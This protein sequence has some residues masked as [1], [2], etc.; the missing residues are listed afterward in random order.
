MLRI[1][2]KLS[3][4]ASSSS[5]ALTANQ[6]PTKLSPL[7]TS[8]FR[9][10][11]IGLELE[12]HMVVPDAIGMINYALK[13]WRTERSL[14]AF[15]MGLCVLKH[16]ISTELTEG[17]DPKRE[18]SKG[19][20]MLAMSTILY[21]RGEYTEAIEKIEDVQEL[22]NSYLGVRVAALETQAGLYLELRQDDLA[23]AV[24]DKCMKVVENQRQ[25]KDFEVQAKDFEAHFLRAKALKGLIELVNGNV[26]SAD[27]F[28]DKSHDDSKYWDGTAG[29]SYAEFLHKKQDYTKATEVYRSVVHGAVQIKRAGNPYLGAGNMSVDELIVGSMCALGQL[30]ALTGNYYWAEHRLGQALSRAEEAYGDSKHPTLGVAL[31]SIALMYR[32]KA[33][34]EHSSSLLI[35]EGLYRKVMDILKVPSEET[36]T[37][38]AA[39][40][41]DRS[42]IAALARGAYAEVLSVQ[43]DRKDEGEKLKNLAESIWKHR[44]MSLAEALETDTNIIDSRISR[45]I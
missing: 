30:E 8:F 14:G 4:I 21:E 38:G 20:A 16:C 12:D 37:E 25:A 22:T 34:Q 42:D 5:S 1:A 7:P 18:N 13:V 40:L 10:F 27:D 24:A 3:S 26:D 33:I 23:A 6:F 36:K 41:V 17:K 29:L 9:P 19:M 43:E 28:F 2:S 11:T 35:Q 32:R 39:P 44:R 31:A 15:R 45:I